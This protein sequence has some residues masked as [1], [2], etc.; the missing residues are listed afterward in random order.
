MPVALR[1]VTLSLQADTID[2]LRRLRRRFGT[3]R[4]V[5]EWF[6]EEY[7]RDTTERD[8]LRTVQAEQR[9][10]ETEARCATRRHEA[11]KRAEETR[12]RQMMHD[13]TM[14]AREVVAAIRSDRCPRC[15][16]PIAPAL[17]RTA[18][19]RVS[20]LDPADEGPASE[21]A[22]RPREAAAAEPSRTGLVETPR[23]GP[24]RPP[25][26]DPS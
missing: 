15:S 12:Y 18:L 23:R 17:E 22:A 7:E 5:V 3:Y 6:L 14:R 25:E 1:T 9:R 8:R 21:A 2:G 26:D 10:L 16:Y 19:E 13:R 24:P 11:D 20:D 4:A